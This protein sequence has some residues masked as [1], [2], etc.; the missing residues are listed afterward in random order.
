MAMRV[1]TAADE[2]A[3]FDIALANRQRD[4]LAAVRE[5]LAQSEQTGLFDA[6]NQYERTGDDRIA[7]CLN[8]MGID[9]L[10]REIDELGE[11]VNA[12]RRIVDGTFGVCVECG[13]HIT[14]SRLSVNPAA[15]RC[16]A[17]QLKK[18]THTGEARH[19]A[20]GDD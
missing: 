7:D 4:I 10:Q 19:R 1:A 3:A 16:L 14:P 8:D 2:L 17:C 5:H 20:V 11:I 18:E 6:V 15:T 12:R 9:Q 13:D